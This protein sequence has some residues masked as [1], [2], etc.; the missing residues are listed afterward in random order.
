MP[1]HL[2]HPTKPPGRIYV[3][4]TPKQCFLVATHRRF[5]KVFEGTSTQVMTCMINKW[6]AKISQKGLY[7]VR[8]PLEKWGGELVERK[9]IVAK[10]IEIVFKSKV[11]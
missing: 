6:R 7:N 3:E 2:M 5:G 11:I 1:P 8:N 10:R 4:K 9:N